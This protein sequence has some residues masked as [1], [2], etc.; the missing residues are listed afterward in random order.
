MKYSIFIHPNTENS[1]AAS[2]AVNF[3]NAL[4]RKKHQITG[5]FFYGHAVNCAF[6][7]DPEWQ[8]IFEQNIKLSAC[9][10]IAEDYLHHGQSAMSYFTLSG[11]GQ[12][13]DDQ[14]KADKRVEF[15]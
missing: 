6:N 3:I 11:L 1:A 4:F 9:S 14:L 15:V 13:M 10:T 5:V 2:H 7:F 8:N 12:W